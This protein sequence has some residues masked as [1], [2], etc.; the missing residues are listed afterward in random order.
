MLSI[1]ILLLLI[2]LIL[3]SLNI[4]YIVLNN[5][6]YIKSVY[7]GGPFDA[8]DFIN[9]L[10]SMTKFID[11]KLDEGIMRPTEIETARYN[12]FAK[13]GALHIKGNTDYDSHNPSLIEHTNNIKLLLSIFYDKYISDIDIGYQEI[14]NFEKKTNFPDGCLDS[15]LTWFKDFLVGLDMNISSDNK[16]LKIA[17]FIEK[18]MR[19]MCDRNI[20]SKSVYFMLM[21]KERFLQQ[22][23]NNEEIQ[24]AIKLN[25]ITKKDIEDILDIIWEDFKNENKNVLDCDGK[26]DKL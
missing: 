1:F 17:E 4:A 18:T 11:D 3:L 10:S 5:N 13:Y 8:K 23:L 7:G 20:Q 19:S 25:I 15:K 16:E 24:R 6:F 14:T 12:E 9:N 26:F 22:I 2:L 21:N